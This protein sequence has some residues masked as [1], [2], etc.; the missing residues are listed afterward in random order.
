[1]RTILKKKE[2][3]DKFRAMR[4]AQVIR[5]WRVMEEGWGIG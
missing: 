4:E 5:E 3:R 2:I 1:M